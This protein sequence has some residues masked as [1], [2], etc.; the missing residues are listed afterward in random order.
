MLMTH[1]VSVVIEQDKDFLETLAEDERSAE[2]SQGR[3]AVS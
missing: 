1:K 2:L 3:C